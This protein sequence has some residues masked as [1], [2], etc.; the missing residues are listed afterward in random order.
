MAR[1]TSAAA[2][3]Q[4]QHTPLIPVFYHAEAPYAKR[5]LQ[6]CYA[7]GVRMFEFTNRGPH[8]FEV[9]SELQAFVE[10]EYPD[11]LLG[12]GTIYTAAE[13]ERF[14]AAG[15]DFIVQPVISAEVAAVCQRHDLAWLPGAMT[16][17][18]IYQ[19]TQLGATLVKI[20]PASFV[21]PAYITTLRGP[22]PQVPFMVTG[23]IEPDP[24]TLAE[25]FR[26]GATCVGIGSQLFKS[27]D[28]AAL[29]ATIAELLRGINALR[30]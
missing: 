25:W 30:S 16:L 7:G 10:A 23:G 9:F 26:A 4:A 18:E 3:A 1:F 27:D 20:F 14:I 19:A 5:M 21:G 12:A 22:L 2:L 17:N 13:A 6:A 24:A 15:A 8:A 28:P 29:S 11:L